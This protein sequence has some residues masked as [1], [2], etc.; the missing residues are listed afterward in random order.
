MLQYDGRLE[1]SL[2]QG[3]LFGIFMVIT[4]LLILKMPAPMIS[5]LM[6][7]MFFGVFMYFIFP[8]ILYK[9]PII[10]DRQ[11][12]A[13][14]GKNE[15]LLVKIPANLLRGIKG[16]GGLG[17]S[18]LTAGLLYLTDS[19]L[20]FKPHSVKK[21]E[22][23]I[24]LNNIMDVGKRRTMRIIPNGIFVRTRLGDEYRFIVWRRDEPIQ[25]LLGHPPS[26]IIGNYRAR[27]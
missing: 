22:L 13:E 27:S 16:V 14:L 5:G 15:E 24:P 19:R 21:K 20:F 26:A 11:A 3:I 10:H 8:I 1:L 18:Y 6:A 7:G 4:N 9:Y 25:L 12:E 23:E 17:L 2:L